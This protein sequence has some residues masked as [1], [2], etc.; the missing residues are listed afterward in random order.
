[1]GVAGGIRTN[2][3]K[4]LKMAESQ[5]GKKQNEHNENTETEHHKKLN[6]P[7]GCSLLWGRHSEQIH[8]NLAFAFIPDDPLLGLGNLA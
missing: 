8:D 3:G 1:M 5:G 2:Y 7:C 4:I 6:F